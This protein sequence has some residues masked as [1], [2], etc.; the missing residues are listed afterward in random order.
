[1]IR[2]VANE[3]LPDAIERYLERLVPP[4]RHPALREMEALAIERG[5]PIVGPVVGRLLE[6]LA[7]TA[8]ARRVLELG[9]GF[10]YSA[11]HFAA[12]VGPGGFVV[13]TEKDSANVALGRGFLERMGLSSRVDFR[14]GEAISAARMIRETFDLAF[15]D[16]DKEG[17]PEALDAALGRLAP[18]GL[19][20]AD[21]ALLSGRV[22][23]AGATDA[24]TLAVREY[25]RR[26]LAIPGAVTTVVPIR[27]GV[28]VTHLGPAT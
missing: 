26:V 16:V 1:M 18:G 17:Y 15:I 3:L 25:T 6:L 2:A 5:F 20:V 28:A 22:A 24:R 10:G 8:R 27:D 21:N 11:A 13:A 14:I 7:R 9:S 23:D 12:A 4:G 19:V